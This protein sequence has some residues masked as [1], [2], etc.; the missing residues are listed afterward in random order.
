MQKVYYVYLTCSQDAEATEMNEFSLWSKARKQHRNSL[1]NNH[2]Y[3]ILPGV[4][5]RLCVYVEGQIALFM[6]KTHTIVSSIQATLELIN[7]EVNRQQR[8]IRTHNNKEEVHPL[9]KRNEEIIENK[10]IAQL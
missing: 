1:L 4:C 3:S 6:Q 9:K 5:G 10:I 8:F 2:Q 7:R